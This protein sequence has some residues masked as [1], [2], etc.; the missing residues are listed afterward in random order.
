MTNDRDLIDRIWYVVEGVGICMLTTRFKGG[1]RAR[2]L[3][4]RP[5]FLAQGIQFTQC[6]ARE[7]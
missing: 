5:L 6:I 2:P 7:L 1:L 4:A 3:E